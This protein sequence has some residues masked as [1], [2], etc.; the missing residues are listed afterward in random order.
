MNEKLVVPTHVGVFRF[1]RMPTVL[2]NV[3]PTHVG[4]F[5]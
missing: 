3:V 1:D 5:R 4:V 2:E